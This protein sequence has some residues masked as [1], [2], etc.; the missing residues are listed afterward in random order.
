MPINASP[1]YGAAKKE[2]LAAYTIEEKIEKLKKMISLAPSHKGAEN[3]RAQLRLKLAKLKKC[4]ET[5]NCK[6]LF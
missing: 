1:E 4:W 6:D 5:R 3:L 2:Y